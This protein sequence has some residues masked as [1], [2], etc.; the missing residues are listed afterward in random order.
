MT[1]KSNNRLPKSWIRATIPELIGTDGLF[2]DGDWVESKD[3][4]PTG[5]IRLIQLADVGDGFYRNRSDRF[6]T[7][8]KA[9]KLGCSFLNVGDVLIA[10]MP[11]PL[12]RCCIFPGDTRKSVTVVDVCIVRPGV[13]GAFS[14]WLMYAINSPQFRADIFKEQSGSTRKRISRGNLAKLIL[15]VPPF[16][17][18]QRIVAKIE[19]L[20]TDLDA[21]ITALK[22]IQLQIKRYRQAVLKA[23]FVGKLTEEWRKSQGDR[24]RET[25]IELLERI[26]EERKK[27]ANNK[28]RRDVQLN[29]P[30]EGLPELPEGWVW[31]SIAELGDLVSGQHILK[32]NYN[33]E[34]KGL[35][36]LTGPADFGSMHPII[37]RWSEKPKTISYKND[38]LITVKGAGVGKVNILDDEQAAISRQLMGIRSHFINPKYL[39]YYL[40]NQFNVIQRIGAGS[41]VPGIDREGILSIMIPISCSK[42]RETIISEIERLFSMADAIKKTVE[43]SLAQSERLRQSILK[44]AFEGKLVPQDPTDPPASEL[45]E[46]IKKEHA[47]ADEIE[48]EAKKKR[49][50]AYTSFQRTSRRAGEPAE[51]LLE[52]IKAE[53]D[54]AQKAGRG[55]TRKKEAEAK[56]NKE[57]VISMKTDSKKR[58]TTKGK[59]RNA[60]K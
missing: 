29:V 51:K 12:G 59:K 17:E 9:K 45:L 26:R 35:P 4:D 16:P 56:S 33:L 11:D 19:E 49:T 41:T 30:T 18:Q 27:N 1:D 43:E 23:A 5:D 42:E 32:D 10:R 44:K 6:M 60:K 50:S 48:K 46:Q 24:K 34:G 22:Q 55:K 38:V 14:K 57:R 47:I 2:V 8:A 58:R 31:I 20:F 37:T 25:G 52:R 40:H 13:V 7:S 3:Q 36:Y 39:F 21:G 54:P 53:R 15:N 28:S